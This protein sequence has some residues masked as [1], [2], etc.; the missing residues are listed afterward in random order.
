MP[1]YTLDPTFGNTQNG[2]TVTNFVTSSAIVSSFGRSIVLDSSENIYMAGYTKKSPDNYDFSI[3]KYTP[4]GVLDTS[5]G[6]APGDITGTVTTDFGSDGKDYA[7]KILFDDVGNMLLSGTIFKI[8]LGGTNHW[9]FAMARYTPSG[10]LD[11]SF[12]IGGLS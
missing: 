11:S 7:Y 9:N 6:G 1:T 12:G 4:D 5:W 2:V 3:A 8:Q 10:V